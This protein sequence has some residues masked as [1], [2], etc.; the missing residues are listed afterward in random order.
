MALETGIL[1][2]MWRFVETSN[3]YT[4][5]KLSDQ[6]IIENLTRQVSNISFL[7]SDDIQILSAYI[8]ARTTLIRDLA[9]SKLVLG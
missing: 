2:K 6:E 8:A 5:V 9:Q 3:P 1:R 4:I 7:T